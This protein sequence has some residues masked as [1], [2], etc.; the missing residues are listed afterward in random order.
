MQAVF[1]CLQKFF[2]IEYMKKYEIQKFNL[3]KKMKKTIAFF[4]VIQY[5]II[6]VG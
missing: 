6:I 3:F 5:N 4:S 1:C 2:R